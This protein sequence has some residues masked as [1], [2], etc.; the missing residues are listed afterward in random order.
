MYKS[1]LKSIAY[2]N[3]NWYINDEPQ[4]KKE[5]DGISEFKDRAL[6]ETYKQMGIDISNFAFK[7]IYY[8]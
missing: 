2:D 1:A 3:S 5:G 6:N 8:F 4:G 7:S